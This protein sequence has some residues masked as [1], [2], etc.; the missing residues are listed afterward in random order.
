MKVLVDGD[1]V[2]YR[3]AYSTQD[4]FPEDAESK[5]DELMDY[6]LTETLIFPDPNDYEVFLTGSGNFRYDIAKSFPYKGNRK[7]TEK[8]I[9]LPVAREHQKKVSQLCTKSK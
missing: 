3:A 6:I 8:P 2:A 4:L 9:H 1:I 5:V 7:S